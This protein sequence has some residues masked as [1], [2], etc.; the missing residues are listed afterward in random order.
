MLLSQRPAQPRPGLLIQCALAAF[1]L[2]LCIF[3]VRRP[4]TAPAPVEAAAAPAPSPLAAAAAA[5]SLQFVN[6]TY[7][8]LAH[9]I[10][11]SSYPHP[12]RRAGFKAVNNANAIKYDS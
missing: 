12:K 5:G 8:P 3:A 9:S 4:C 2:L 10:N 1:I 7:D 11:A 6:V